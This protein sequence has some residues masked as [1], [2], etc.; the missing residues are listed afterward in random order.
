MLQ[1]IAPGF[2]QSDEP[3]GRDEIRLAIA[4]ITLKVT[5]QDRSRLPKPDQ[6]RSHQQRESNSDGGQILDALPDDPEELAA[7]LQALA[8]PSVGPNGGQ[9]FI[10]GF[11]G[12]SLPSKDSIREIRINQNP[13]GAEKRSTFGAYRHSHSSRHR[14]TARRRVVQL[15]RESFNSCNPFRS[16]RAS[17][18]RFRFATTT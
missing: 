7:A 14:Q 8:G 5:I 2:T 13:F 1:A 17:V 15:Q 12:G 10:D 9:I 4:D 3:N 11:T 6:H 16:T 18:R